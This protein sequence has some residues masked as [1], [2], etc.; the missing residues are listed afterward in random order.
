[1][2]RFPNL[3]EIIITIKAT[4]SA[5][6]ASAKK[7][8]KFAQIRP[9]KTTSELTGK[10][11]QDGNNNNYITPNAYFNICVSGDKTVQCLINNP[12]TSYKEEYCFEK[13]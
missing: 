11:Y 9:S 3:Y 2:E 10:I 13:G 5:A 1:M 8:P 12:D 6:T 4:I 7:N